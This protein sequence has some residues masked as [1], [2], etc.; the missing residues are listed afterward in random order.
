MNKYHRLIPIIVII[1]LKI[2]S[3]TLII[4]ERVNIWWFSGA[5]VVLFFCWVGLQKY[6]KYKVRQSIE[7]MKRKI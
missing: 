1:I 5:S 3:V 4:L 2:V 7:K 6:R